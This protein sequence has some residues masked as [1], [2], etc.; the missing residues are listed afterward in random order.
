[1]EGQVAFIGFRPQ[2]ASLISGHRVLVHAARMENLPITLIEALSRG[3]PILA[4]AVGGI[5]EIF[6]HAVEGYFWPLDDVDGAAVLL[7]S[8]LSNAVVYERLARAARKRYDSRFS[9]EMLVPAWL[10]AIFKQD[11][12]HPA[13]MA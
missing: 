11:V 4:P 2:A 6:S 1:M 5:G 7:I 13:H 9:S 12:F 8:L 3:R 10:T